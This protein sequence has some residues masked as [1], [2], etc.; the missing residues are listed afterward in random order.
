MTLLKPIVFRP[1][2]ITLFALA[3]AALTH[4]RAAETVPINEV[5]GP[6]EPSWESLKQYQCPEW[7]RDAKFGIWAHWSAQ[8]VPEQGDWYAR[9][10]YIQGEHD[11]DYH[12]EHYGH[13]SKVG[14]KE[15]DAA[16]HAEHWNPDKLMAL[17][18]RAG[19]KYFVALANHHDNFDCYDSK[20]Q[21]WNS[22]NI[23]PHKDIVGGWAKA[24]RKKG[25]R[26]GVTVHAARAWKWYEVA[27]GS[28]TNGPL[29]GVPYDGTLTKA[30]GKGTWWEGYDP[31]DL[32]AQNHPV[33]APPSAEYME[34]FFN[35][36]IDLVD[37]YRPD[38]LYFDDAVLPFAK[39]S[40]VG[41]RIAAHY[42]NAN[43]RWHQ[44]RNEA[45]MNT[46]GLKEAQRQSLVWDI[47]R[48]KSTRIE[49][50]VWQTDT[51]IGNWHYSRSLYERHGYKSA[52]AVVQMLADIVSKNGN[53]LLD[54]PV[55]GDG[56]IDEDEI[57]I[58]EDLAGWM[59]VNSSAIFG[60]RPWRVHGE[61]AP[62][63]PVVKLSLSERTARPYTEEDIRFTTKED[64]L[65][66]IGMAW[67]SSGKLLIK[68]LAS[69][70]EPENIRK[71]Q[72]L[73]S[74]KKVAWTRTAAGLEVTLPKPP[75]V[76]MNQT[77]VSPKYAGLEVTLPKVSH[78]QFPFV[79]KITK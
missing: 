23:G 2:R 61:G 78:G 46:K 3:F 50:F 11:Y 15:I 36:T 60:T 27:Q 10:M 22:V 8:C 7:F 79:L 42:Y 45:V 5:S 35:R 66:A 67:P 55:R 17:Y 52:E 71:L 24:A 72:L 25:L 59:K 44:G 53:L 31:Q 37:K 51:C 75:H 58:L 40:D 29:A 26:F 68:T 6:F 63:Q 30:Q 19:A 9:K 13:P 21:P 18:K 39:F 73:G 43:G 33:G 41:L 76:T 12:V 54:V 28:D 48:G 77:L 56:T 70:S 64:T 69:G 32:Y 74:R 4:V 38:L 34:K 14:F 62:E 57:K 47:E 49:P 65:F 20:Y 1:A 16:W